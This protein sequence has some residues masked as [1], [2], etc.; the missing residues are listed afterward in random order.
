MNETETTEEV[1]KA[2]VICELG[3]AE[4]LCPPANGT[5]AIV[6]MVFHTIL[7]FVFICKFN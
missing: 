5:F 3:F 6:A 4:P 7:S 1:E 2:P